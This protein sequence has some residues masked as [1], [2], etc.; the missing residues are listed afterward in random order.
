MIQ[1]ILTIVLM[2]LAVFLATSILLQARGAGLDAAFGGE[3]TVFRSRHG[4]EKHLHTLSI[5][6]A[7]LFFGV[8]LALALL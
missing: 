7:I 6:F 2:V 5:V 8:A 1:T 4:V 3:G